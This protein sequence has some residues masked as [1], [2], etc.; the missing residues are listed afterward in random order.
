MQKLFAVATKEIKAAVI[1]ALW[2]G[3]RK[4]DLLVAP[5]S[6]YDGKTIKVKQSKTGARV[7]IPCGN[8]LKQI[9]DAMP[10]RSTVILTNTRKKIPG[11][12]MASTRRSKNESKGWHRGSDLP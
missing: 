9:L 1:F 8:E 11:R 6:D 2:T 12:R 7:K 5:W 4:G 3:Q 10:R